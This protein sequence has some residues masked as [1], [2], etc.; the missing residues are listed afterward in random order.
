M[1]TQTGQRQAGHYED[2]DI[3]EDAD[4][5]ARSSAEGEEE[6][7]GVKLAP[8]H[9]TRSTLL[10]RILSISIHPINT[11]V[12]HRDTTSQVRNLFTTQ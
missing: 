5:A 4:Y 7:V 10:V 12:H 3:H 1:Y 2:G 6:E 11:S 9:H 8:S